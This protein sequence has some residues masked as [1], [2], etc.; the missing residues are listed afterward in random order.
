MAD[1]LA[2]C[3][4]AFILW[5]MWREWGTC[6]V[7][8]SEFEVPDEIDEGALQFRAFVNDVE[9]ELAENGWSDR[10]STTTFT[11]SYEEPLFDEIAR[12]ENEGGPAS[13]D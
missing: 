4:I 12:F 3:C 8:P 11:V 6:Y 7:P 2:L 13:G 9:T 1:F 5:Y 10:A